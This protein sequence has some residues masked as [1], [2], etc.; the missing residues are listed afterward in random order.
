MNLVVKWYMREVRKQRFQVRCQVAIQQG[1]I[2][3]ELKNFV[4]VANM[5]SLV[6]E[7]K[8]CSITIKDFQSSHLLIG[9]DFDCKQYLRKTVRFS[10][11][12]MLA[13][14]YPS[15]FLRQMDGFSPMIYQRTDGRLASYLL[16]FLAP[17]S[18]PPPCFKVAKSLRIKIIFYLTGRKKRYKNLVEALKRYEKRKPV[19]RDQTKHRIALEITLR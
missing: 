17:L 9:I 2:C 14:K 11:Q 15:I 13:D 10:G 4:S 6:S 7:R 5:A 16:S 12:V 19:K 18:P 3:R 8:N 1:K